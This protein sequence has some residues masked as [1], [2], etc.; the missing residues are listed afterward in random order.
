MPVEAFAPGATSSTRIR[1]HPARRFA[2]PVVAGPHDIARAVR[3]SRSVALARAGAVDGAFAE[4]VAEAVEVAA[5]AVRVPV[6]QPGRRGRM[7]ASRSR[8]P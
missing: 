4:A 6:V 5:A 1:R 2:E 8:D 3:A 7:T